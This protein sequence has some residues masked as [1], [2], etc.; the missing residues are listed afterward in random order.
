ME[1]K[2]MNLL[3]EFICLIL[4]NFVMMMLSPVQVYPYVTPS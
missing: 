4:H 1:K 2:E 3:N